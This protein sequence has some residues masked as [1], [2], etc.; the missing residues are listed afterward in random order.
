MCERVSR[1]RWEVTV[2]DE[3]GPRVEE[4]E[5]KGWA[6][7]VDPTWRVRCWAWGQGREAERTWGRIR[8]SE[9]GKPRG[10]RKEGLA[11]HLTHLKEGHGAQPE[12]GRGRPS[13]SALAAA[14][15]PET[16]QERARDPWRGRRDVQ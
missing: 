3:P 4:A 14:E 7:D 5:K 2:G 8:G 11:P 15:G 6:R 9:M 13:S 1:V 12:T 16:G 10:S